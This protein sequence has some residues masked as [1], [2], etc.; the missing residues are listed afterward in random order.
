MAGYL[1]PSLVRGAGYLPPSLVLCFC[2]DYLLLRVVVANGLLQQ[3]YAYVFGPILTQLILLVNFTLVL[4]IK[5]F[6]L[7]KETIV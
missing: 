4:N 2:A 7:L 6:N 1:L 5:T 3:R